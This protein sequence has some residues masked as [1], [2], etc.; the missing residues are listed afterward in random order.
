MAFLIRFGPAIIH[1]VPLCT[2]PPG[3]T[4]IGLIRPGISRFT[5][6]K[7]FI[8]SFTS[9]LY[10]N[11]PGHLSDKVSRL[12]SPGLG[13]LTT[14]LHS[15]SKWIQHMC[16]LLSDLQYMVCPSEFGVDSHPKISESVNPFQGCAIETVGLMESLCYFHDFAFGL[17]KFKLP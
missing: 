10:L 16:C 17:V 1:L 4:L 5:L 12:V 11:H 15:S 3:C 14:F 2:Y 6:I 7:Y 8:H 9:V 13:L